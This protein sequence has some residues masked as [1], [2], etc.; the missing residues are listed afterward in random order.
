METL[1]LV[2]VESTLGPVWVLSGG[3]SAARPD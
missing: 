1:G 2:Y 3:V